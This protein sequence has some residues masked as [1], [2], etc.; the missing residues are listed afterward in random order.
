MADPLSIVCLVLGGVGTLIGIAT[1]LWPRT[2]PAPRETFMPPA[3][4]PSQVSLQE[5]IGCA[6]LRERV[7]ALE[8]R[9]RDSLREA[10][11]ITERIRS[12]K[13]A[14]RGDDG[15]DRGSSA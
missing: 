15:G 5:C 3:P 11:R 9:E 6:S 12:I 13:A 7:G 2:P 8:D 1:Q 14:R 4:Q 10:A